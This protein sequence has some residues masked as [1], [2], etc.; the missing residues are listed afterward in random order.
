MRCRIDRAPGLLGVRLSK[1]RFA[2]GRILAGL[3]LSVIEIACV[4][5]P[6]SDSVL[7]DGDSIGVVQ[8]APGVD[9]AAGAPGDVAPEPIPVADVTDPTP[10]NDPANDAASLD[11]VWLPGIGYAALEDVYALM[12]NRALGGGTTAPDGYAYFERLCRDQGYSE[13]YCRSRYGGN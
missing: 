12:L 5:V 8:P 3:I 6:A 7:G 13:S 4:G 10:I 1:R 9:A 2:D 11:L